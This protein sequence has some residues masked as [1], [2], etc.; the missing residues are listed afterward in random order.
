MAHMLLHS[1]VSPELLSRPTHFKLIEDQ[2]HLFAVAFL[3]PLASFGDDFFAANLDTLV[4][5]KPKWKVSVASMIMR[6][7]RA[8][9]ID[10]S[11][12][13]RLWINLSRRGWRRREPFDDSMEVETPRICRRSFEL[14]LENGQT[15]QDIT[16]RLSLPVGDVESLAGL[17]RGQLSNFA[18]VALRDAPHYESS[19]HPSAQI[20]QMRKKSILN[21]SD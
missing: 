6:A 15:A 10:E 9:F 20:I 4:A 8:E 1:H 19:D 18:P 21:A 5:L 14:M 17:D 16:G 11:T 12:A 7:R 2:A 13:R 3:L